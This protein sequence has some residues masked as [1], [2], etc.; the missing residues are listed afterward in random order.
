[1]EPIEVVRFLHADQVH[2]LAH[3]VFE[4]LKHPL[5]ALLPDAEIHHGGSTAVSDAINKGDLDIQ[6]RVQPLTFHAADDV[7]RGPHRPP[8]ILN[9]HD[10]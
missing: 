1:M 9:F 10:N 3:D 8:G 7:L 6:I 4:S 5:Q 2:A